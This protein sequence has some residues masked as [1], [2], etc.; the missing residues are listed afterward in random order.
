MTEIKIKTHLI[1]TDIKNEYTI[2]WFGK[3]K[4][5]N[6][7]IRNGLPVF[8]IVSSLGRTELNTMDLNEI[9]RVAKNLTRPK[10]R[11]ACSSDCAK[12]FI[13]EKGGAEKHIGSVVHNKIKTY[14]PMYDTVGYKE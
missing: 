8:S 3:L 10:G 6:P 7:E 14:A 4:D 9:E 5:C 12:I 11:S 13:V 1:V 2:N